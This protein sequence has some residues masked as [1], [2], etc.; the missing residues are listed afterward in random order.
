MA[1]PGTA[2]RKDGERED[3]KRMKRKEQSTV[4]GRAGGQSVV[5]VKFLLDAVGAERRDW[6]IRGSFA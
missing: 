1:C 5:V 6:L 3:S 4:A 2:I